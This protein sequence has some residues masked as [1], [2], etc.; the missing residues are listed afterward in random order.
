MSVDAAESADILEFRRSV[1]DWIA[2]N[3]PAPP[4]FLL[5]QTFLEVESRQQFEYL[6]DWQKKLFDAGWLGWETPREYGG[7]GVDRDRHRVVMQELSRARAPF[8]VNTI[9]INWVA[10]TLLAYGTEDQKKKFLKPLYSAEEI[11]C[12]GFS[13]PGAG[14]DLASLSTRAEKTGSGYRVRGH[15]VWTTLAH[16]AKWMILLARTD[17]EVNRYAGI[18][19]FLFPMDAPGVTIQPLVK[20]TG[21]GGF[22]QVLFDDAPMPAGALLGR[23]GQG[24]EIAMTTLMFERGAA[25]GRGQSRS[26]PLFELFER[27]VSL[28]K[29][30]RRDG[31]LVSDDPVFRDRIAALWVEVQAM[32]LSELRSGVPALCAD[33]PLALPMMTKV[34][35]SEWGQR[36]SDLACE[37]LGPDAGLWVGDPHAPDGA[38]W[39]RSFMNSFGMTIGG[40]TS[41][42]LRNVLGE[43][44]LGLPKSK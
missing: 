14:S 5:P 18:S 34:V 8:L 23:E 40:G 19:Y 10:P 3:K 31:R 12:Q 29:R 6:R 42:I 9:A 43:R 24:W 1:R 38:D 13:E 33:R 30:T 11:W 25:E 32:H 22:N 39:P 7:Q 41:E 4:P 21:E 20:M 44:V 15:K 16:F 28:A 27:L 36:L 26:A 37:M 17:P 2:A 35:S